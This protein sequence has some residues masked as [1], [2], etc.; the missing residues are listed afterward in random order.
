MKWFRIS[1]NG[2][3][4][5]VIAA[6]LLIPLRAYPNNPAALKVIRA[7]AKCRKAM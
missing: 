6:L 7:Q 2:T 5:L 4:T 3:I 1:R